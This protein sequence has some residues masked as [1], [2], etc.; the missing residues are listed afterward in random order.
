MEVYDGSLNIVLTVFLISE[1]DTEPRQARQHQLNVVRLK[2]F[3]ILFAISTC[4]PKAVPYSSAIQDTRGNW[5]ENKGMENLIFS[6]FH[7][8]SGF[9]L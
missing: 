7:I 8:I 9:L 6:Y 1:K 5:N 3:Q 4:T 2:R